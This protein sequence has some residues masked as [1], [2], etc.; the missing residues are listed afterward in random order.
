LRERAGGG[1]GGRGESTVEFVDL[2]AAGLKAEALRRCGEWHAPI[3]QK[4]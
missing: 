3:R 4:F 1:G 2:S